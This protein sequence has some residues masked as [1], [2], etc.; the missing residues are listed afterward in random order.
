M[1]KMVSELYALFDE[2]YYALCE[3]GMLTGIFHEASNCMITWYKES[4]T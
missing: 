2:G 1:N 3:D 4:K